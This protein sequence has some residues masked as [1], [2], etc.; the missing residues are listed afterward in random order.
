M[1][2]F[3]SSTTSLNSSFSKIYKVKLNITDDFESI[4]GTDISFTY[5]VI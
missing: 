1:K 4:Q 5:Q 3:N 2:E